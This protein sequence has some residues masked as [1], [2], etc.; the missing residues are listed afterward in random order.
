MKIHVS[1]SGIIHMRQKRV[2]KTDVQYV[3]DKEEIP[4]WSS[5]STWDV[6]LTNI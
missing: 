5:I 2:A 6:W 1:K 3:I 4:W